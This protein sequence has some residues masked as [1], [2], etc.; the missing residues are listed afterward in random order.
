MIVASCRFDR[1]LLSS[2]ALLHVQMHECVG[3]VL[4]TSRRLPIVKVWEFFRHRPFRFL[5][6]APRLAQESMSYWPGLEGKRLWPGRQKEALLCRLIC[7]NSDAS[8]SLRPGIVRVLLQEGVVVRLLQRYMCERF[9]PAI[10]GSS[11]CLASFA[12]HGATVAD[13]APAGSATRVD[14]SLGG[15]EKTYSSGKARE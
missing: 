2:V 15:A 6:V 5:P 13:Q 14:S 9:C 12:T 11:K 7:S 8:Q 1:G 3:G 4:Q 10:S